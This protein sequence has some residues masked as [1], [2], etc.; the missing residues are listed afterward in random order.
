MIGM[1]SSNLLSS[2][3]ILASFL[4]A[5]SRLK[6]KWM[7]EGTPSLHGFRH[8][9]PSWKDWALPRWSVCSRGQA[10][11]VQISNSEPGTQALEAVSIARISHIC[12]Y[13]VL[14][15]QL[16]RLGQLIAAPC[17][18]SGLVSHDLHPK[19]MKTLQ[20]VLHQFSMTEKPMFSFCRR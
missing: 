6:K 7:G 11:G 15:Y 14:Y 12:K 8:L 17:S 18:I 13:S 3:G 20:I 10:G 16:A 19:R 2:S 9:P 4:P 1:V 5:K